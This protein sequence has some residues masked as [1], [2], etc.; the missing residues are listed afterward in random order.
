[1]P[2]ISIVVP[3][4]NVEK[5]LSLCLDSILH[6]SF[7]DYELILVDDGSTDLSGKICD[8]YKSKLD[9]VKVI[10]QKNQGVSAARNRGIEISSGEYLICIDSDD[11]LDSAMF[12]TMV[13]TAKDG[14]YDLVVCGMEHYDEAGKLLFQKLTYELVLNQEQMMESMFAMPDPLGGSV[15]N[16]LFLR[17]KIANVRF[18]ESAKMAEDRMFLYDAYLCLSTCK[19]IPNTFYRVLDRGDS[20]THSASSLRIYEFFKSNYYVL[21]KAR[22][23]SPALESK[24]MD[25]YFDDCLR[26]IPEIKKEIQEGDADGKKALKSSKLLMFKVLLDACLKRKLSMRKIHGYSKALITNFR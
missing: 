21:K 26:Y 1:M 11:T 16:K 2:T 18:N 19:K 6:Q 15:C 10:H 3:V 9:N 22:E 4:Y 12:D 13:N 7:K 8:E 5:Y 23:Y 14:Q 25:K 24:A 17:N 20:A